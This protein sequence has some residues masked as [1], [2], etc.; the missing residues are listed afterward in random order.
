MDPMPGSLPN[1]YT[2]PLDPV[3]GSDLSGEF[4][5][6]HLVSSVV[7]AVVH[8]AKKTIAAAVAILSAVVTTVVRYTQVT[9]R[10]SAQ[11]A[12]VVHSSSAAPIVTTASAPSKPVTPSASQTAASSEV[13]S[14]SLNFT[15]GSAPEGDGGSSG[16]F[17]SGLESI[18]TGVVSS[19]PYNQHSV[20]TG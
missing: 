14:G 12:P 7:K 20:S 3:N 6:S 16:S 19:S 8:A 15:I 18:A 10:A 17:L 4:S 11:S 9:S 13:S 5:F 1:L 2:Y